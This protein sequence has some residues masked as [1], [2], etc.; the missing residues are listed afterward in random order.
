MTG[1]IEPRIPDECDHI[2]E[3]YK[4]SHPTTDYAITQKCKL[5]G[6]ALLEKIN[7]LDWEHL[8]RNVTEKDKLRRR[9]RYGVCKN[10]GC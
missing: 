2:F 7:G 8:A 1:I 10:G 5:C 4:Q 6:C 9:P 3:P